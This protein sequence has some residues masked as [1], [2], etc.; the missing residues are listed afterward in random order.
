M[1]WAKLDDKIGQHPKTVEAGP[2]A[3]LLYLLSLAYCGQYLTDG[4]IGAKAIYRLTDFSRV[5][6]EHGDPVDELELAETLVE[7]RL[8]EH[9]A[10]GYQIH[11][12]LDY[13]FSKSQVL[14]DRQAAKDRMRQ[15]R[16]RQ[17]RDEAGQFG[18]CSP[19][20][21]ENIAECSAE[22]T[23]SPSP[24]PSPSLTTTTTA[25][26]SSPNLPMPPEQMPEFTPLQ[27]LLDKA[28]VWRSVDGR[29][30]TESWTTVFEETGNNLA[31]ME[32]TLREIVR[33]G[34]TATPALAAKIISDCKLQNRHPGQRFQEKGAPRA[35][36]PPPKPPKKT[37]PVAYIDWTDG[38]KVKIAG[39]KEESN[40]NGHNGHDP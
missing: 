23:P 12:Y 3:T 14:A 20:Q 18:K 17:P 39:E 16:E 34:K 1:V 8:W 7:C 38:N 29:M 25:E 11:D 21:Q 19:E 24:S 2:H 40:G 35:P 32:E 9:A 27:K 4:F 13:N 28:G 33:V 6:D 31:F 36:D 10:N 15:T 30:S 26:K 22:V 5:R 37:G